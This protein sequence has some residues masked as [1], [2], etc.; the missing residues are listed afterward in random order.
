M[1][2]DLCDVVRIRYEDR[3]YMLEKRRVIQEGKNAGTIAWDVV[4][5]YASFK[6]AAT[7]LVGGNFHL[8]EAQE[9]MPVVKDLKTLIEAIDYG[10]DLIARACEGKIPQ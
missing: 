6:Q 10:A 8:L 3:N 9:G 5:Y 7:S 4:G 2:I 1:I